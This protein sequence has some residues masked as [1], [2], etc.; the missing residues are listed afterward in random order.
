MP[1]WEEWTLVVEEESRAASKEVEEEGVAAKQKERAEPPKIHMLPR[2]MKLVLWGC[3][4]L[5]VLPQQLGQDATSLKIII[6]KYMNSIK[7]VESLPFLSEV[8]TVACEGLQRVSN[9]PQLKRMNVRL[10]P[11]LRHVEGLECLHELFLTEDMQGVSS[12]WLPGLQEQHRELH[13]EDMDVYN[14]TL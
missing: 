2:L 13:G 6:L 9:I 1:N 4:K 5:R 11:N 7:M 10:C 8:S 14:W 3:P 12:Q